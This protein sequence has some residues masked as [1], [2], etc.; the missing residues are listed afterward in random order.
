MKT[1]ADKRIM[2]T[3]YSHPM[4]GLRMRWKAFLA[5]EPGSGDDSQASVSIEDGEGTPVAEGMFEFAG[6]ALAVRGGRAALRCADFIRGKHETG[7][8]LHRKGMAPV[9]GVLTFE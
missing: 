2:F 6:Q 7:I 3:L 8:W 4:K 5:F 1:P 9:P